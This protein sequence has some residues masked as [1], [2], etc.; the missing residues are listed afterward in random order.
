MRPII[1]SIFRPVAEKKVFKANPLSLQTSRNIGSLKGTQMKYIY[2]KQ[3]AFLAQLVFIALS[4]HSAGSI[5]TQL[6]FIRLY[7]AREAMVEW[8]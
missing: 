6:L 2:A 4:S 1:G 8:P 3:W 7:V 5:Y